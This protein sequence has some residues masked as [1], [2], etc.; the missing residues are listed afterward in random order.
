MKVV[1]IPAHY[2]GFRHLGVSTN[3]NLL[4]S[5]EAD[6]LHM[7]FVA[8]KWRSLGAHLFRFSGITL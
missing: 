1:D 8:G 3:Q 5:S 4:F 7:Q 2:C 6:C